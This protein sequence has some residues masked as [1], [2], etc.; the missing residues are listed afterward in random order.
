MHTMLINVRV[1]SVCV[2][3]LHCAMRTLTQMEEEGAM[4]S[5]VGV[6][7]KGVREGHPSWCA[8]KG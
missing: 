6:S 5:V 4:Q 3:K 8:A 7:I 2:C 1:K